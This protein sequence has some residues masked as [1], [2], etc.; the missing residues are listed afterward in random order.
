[1]PN[2]GKFSLLR[3]WLFFMGIFLAGLAAGALGSLALALTGRGVQT[4][5]PIAR[6]LDTD[7][8][9]LKNGKIIAG[10]ILS[11]N[12][13]E[14]VLEIQNGTLKLKPDEIGRIE[15]NYYTRYFKKVW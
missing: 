8:L 1:M 14:L 9:Y 10:R 6:W 3:S 13:R 11:R 5:L 2:R 12:D 15:E 4:I 7:F